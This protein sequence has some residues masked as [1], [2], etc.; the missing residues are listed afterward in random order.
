MRKLTVVWDEPDENGLNVRQ[1]IT[2]EEAVSRQRT[3]A[4]RKNYEYESKELA[5]EDFLTIHYAW[6]EEE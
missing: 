6:L 5:L 2:I 1:E 4:R 3:A